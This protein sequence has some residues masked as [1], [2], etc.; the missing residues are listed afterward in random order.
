MDLKAPDARVYGYLAWGRYSSIVPNG[1]YQML[2]PATNGIGTGPFMLSG[3]YVPNTGMTF[4]KNPNFWKSG[5]PYL[6]AITYKIITDEQTRIAALRAGAIHGA[7]VSA[8]SAAALNGANGLTV[9][10]GLNASFREL[11]FTVKSGETKPWHDKRVRQAVNF[12]I[13]RQN[14]ID[15]VYGGFGKVLRAR[16][17]RLRP[18][19][20]LPGRAADELREVRPAQGR[21]R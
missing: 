14:I 11:Q 18:V 1:M 16:R 21:R 6:D 8:D 13:N 20:A 9:L 15:K 19:A 2:D 5:L 7:T 17:G 12:A 3:P 10:H 4:V